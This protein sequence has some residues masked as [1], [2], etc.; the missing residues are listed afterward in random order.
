MVGLQ[1]PQLSMLLVLPPLLLLLLLLGPPLLAAAVA[2]TTAPKRLWL[3]IAELPSVFVLL[4][5]SERESRRAEALS[6]IYLCLEPSKPYS[7]LH[8]KQLI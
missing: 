6:P 3:G 2:A 7:Q 4:L 5:L 8:A 1:R